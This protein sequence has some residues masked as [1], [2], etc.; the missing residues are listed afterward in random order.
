MTPATAPA[1][2]ASTR[3]LLD[4]QQA[5]FRAEGAVSAAT[6]RARLQRVIDMLVQHADALVAAMGEDFGGRPAVFSLMNDVAGALASLKFARDHLEGW[7]PDQPRPAVSPFDQFGATA[8]VRYQPKG[9]VG[10]IGTW[11]A[12]LFTLFSPLSSVLAAG[13]RAILKPS[14]VA[15]RT[16]AVVAAA[17]AQ[18]F[19]ADELAVVTGG[20]DVAADFARQPFNHLVFTGSTA[21]GKLIMKAAAE[22]L[23]PVTLELGGKSPVLIGRSADIRNAAERIAVGKALNSGQLCVSPD[24][25]WVHASQREALIAGLQEFYAGQYPSIAGNA[26]VTPVV[27]DRHFARVESYVADAGA[28]GARIVMAGDWPTAEGAAERR[29]PLRLVI[30][31]PADAEIACHEIFGP[32]LVLRSY[33]A[34]DEA[35][36]ELNAGERPLALYYFGQDAAE[37]QRVLD[38]TLSGGVSINDVAMHPA[39]HDAPFGGVGASGMGHYHGREGFLE[40]SHARAIY[41]AGTHDPRRD[42]GLLPPYSDQLA[43][44]LRGAIVS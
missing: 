44:M 12:P 10:I 13:N 18:C 3:T 37:Q 22:N 25:V 9:V 23:V 43:Q 26:D 6:R 33:Q 36:A 21:V 11:N 34:L 27:N 19:A 7:M 35:L 29:M 24:T 39:L 14:E 17:V 8:W 20:A 40:F 5:A 32:A 4:A 16:A 15:P 38:H 41:N 42:W 1:T 30:D 2:A 28:R 31:P